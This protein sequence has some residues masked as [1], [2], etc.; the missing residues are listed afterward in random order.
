MVTGGLQKEIPGEVPIFR[1]IFV[2]ILMDESFTIP[3]EETKVYL[4]AA[5][6]LVNL[7]G[8][9]TLEYVEF[10]CWLVD[11]LQDITDKSKSAID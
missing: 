8:E 9:L 11:V 3:T 10:S 1:S 5:R 6:V 2:S 7:Y 4:E